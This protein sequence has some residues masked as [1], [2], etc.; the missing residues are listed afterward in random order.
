MTKLLRHDQRTATT[1]NFTAQN[2]QWYHS[3]DGNISVK[4]NSSDQT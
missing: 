2:L 3:D 1:D 4:M